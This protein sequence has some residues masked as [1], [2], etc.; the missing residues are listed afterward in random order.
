MKRSWIILTVAFLAG[1]VPT[2][3]DPSLV[4]NEL[5]ARNNAGLQDSAGD[6]DDWIEIYNLDS[7]SVDVGGMHLTDNLSNPAK[8]RIPTGIPEQTTIAPNGF[9]LIWADGEEDQGPL[10]AGFKLGDGGEAVGL[11]D[12][13]GVLLDSL[14]FGPQDPDKSYGRF[15]D[16]R[17][18][19]QS[20]NCP[21]PGQPNERDH[22]DVIISEIM[23]HPYA[24][25]LQAENRDEEYIELFNR[26]SEAVSL[27]GWTITEGVRFGFPDV[28]LESGGYLVVA[29]DVEAFAARYPEV[30]NVVGGWD[31]RLSNSGETVELHDTA[32]VVVDRV[33]YADNGDWSV[34][35]L[36]PAQYGH[37]GWTWRDDHDGGGKSLEL[38]N[39]TLSN[40]FGQNWIASDPNGGTPGIANSVATT[41]TTPLIAD[42]G[43]VP[44]VPGP[45]D[46]VT[47]TARVA[48]AANDALTVLLRYR[49]DTSRYTNQTGRAAYPIF[50]ADSYTSLAM[51]DDGAHGDGMA[52]DGLY[53]AE[54]PPHPDGTVIEFYVQATDGAGHARTWPAPSIIDG[55]VQ[56]VT[57]ALYQV[58]AAFNPYTYWQIG[59]QPL[60]YMVMTEAERGRLAY[61]GERR[62][63]ALSHAQMNGTFISVDGQD[64]LLRYN[65]GIRN[66]GNGSRMPPPN[67]YRVNFP[68]DRRWK[69]VDAININSKY[70]YIQL[71]GQAVFH[72]AGLPAL[73]AKRVQVRVNGQDLAPLDPERMYGSYVHLEVYDGDWADHHFPDD[74]GGNL[75]RC[76]SRSR[77]CDLRYQGEDPASYG[78]ADWYRKKTNT[79]ANDWSD[80]TG[81][82]YALDESPDGTYVRDVE[83]VVNVDQ[84]LRWFALMALVVN[85][86]TNLSN[87]YGD[88]Y[89]MY[90][91]AEDERFMLLP[92]DLDSVLISPDPNTSIWLA[93]R[94]DNL[95]V[96]KR[97]L[98]HPE[99]VPR[100]YAQLKDLAETVLAPEQFNPLVEQLLGDWVPQQTVEAIQ[101][102]AAARRAYVL[103]VIPQTFTATAEIRLA[104]DYPA[105][106]VPHVYDREICGTANAI[107]TQSV[108][109][110][111]Q[112][113]TWLPREGQ[114]M[115]GATTLD[116]F[117]GINRM[118][119]EAF[120][121]PEGTG[122]KLGEAYADVYYRTGFT[123]DYPQIA[124]DGALLS[125]LNESTTWTADEGPYRIT[126]DLTVPPGV[127]LTIG[128]GTTVFFDP[129]VTMTIQGRLVAEGSDYELLRFTRSPDLGGTW[130]GLQFVDTSQ[131]NRI[132]HA[133]IEYG[134][135]NNGMIGLENSRLH[136]EHVTF[137]HTD[138]RRI[139]TI[140]SSL[141]V[142]DSRFT[143]VVGPGE[144]PTTDNYSEHIWGSGV[145]ENGQFIIEGNMFGITPGHNDAIDFDGATRPAAIPQ[146]LNNVF[147]GGGDDALD[148]E[149][150]AHVEGNLF[151]NYVEDEFNNAAGESN[152]I[153]AGAGREYVVVR[154]VFYHIGHVAQIKERAFMIFENNTV[155]DANASA[156]Y[157]EIPG[158]TRSPGV[159]LWMDSCVFRDC[160][161][162]LENFFI[163]DPDW[164]TTEITVNRC[165]MPADWHDWG[166]GNVD[167]DPLFVGAD[168]F[169]LRPISPARQMG[170][171]GLDMGAYVPTGASVGG[172]P[173]ARTHR[174]DATLQVWGPGV[175][176]Y[177]YSLNDPDGPWSDERPI[178]VPI[179]LTDL[180]DGDAYTVYVLGKNSAGIWQ[181]QANASRTWTVDATYRRLQLN[182]IMAA[183]ETAYER[184]GA[185]PDALELYYDGP[186]AINLAGM[187][188]SD[189]PTEPDKFVFPSGV[190]MNPGDYLVLWGG[191]NTGAG[192]D[193]GFG[194]DAEGDGVFLYDRDGTV[195]DSVVFGHQLPD[196]P[197]GRIG[198]EGD[199]HLTLPTLGE[200][201]VAQPLGDPNAVKINEWLTG[202][203]V[204]FT[205]DFIELYNPGDWPV[206]VGAF[207]LTDDP[208]SRPTRHEIRPLS[209]IGAEG[210]V[211]FDANGVGE[212]G[213]ANLRLATDGEVV[214]LLDPERRMVNQI[215]YGPQTPDVSQG[216]A[217]D[218]ADLLEWFALPTPGTANPFVR[219]PLITRVTLVH[220]E[221]EK[222]VIIPLSEEHIDDTWKSDPLFDDSAWLSV[223]GAPGGI[224]YERSIGYEDIIGLDVGDQ[225]YEI[226]TSCY[227]RIPFN[228]EDAAP[229]ELSDLI[230]SLRYDDGYIV[231][232]NGV[233]VARYNFSDAPRWNSSAQ[234]SHESF[235]GVFDAVLDLTSYGDLL[236]E[237][238]NLL[239]IHGLNA[240]LTSGDFLISAALEATVVEFAGEEHPHLR[241]LQLLD[242]LR[243]TELM[244]HAPQ[245]DSGDYIELQNISDV[246]LD[247]TGL[248]FTDG[249]EFVFPSM[250]L[251][252]GEYA[253]VV[254]DRAQ[255]ESIYGAGVPLAGEYSGRLSN[256]GEHVVLKLPSPWEMA[257]M[258]FAYE[259]CWH[260]STDGDGRSLV[261]EELTA[262]PV[263]WNDPGN[264][265]A[266]LPSPGRP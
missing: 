80:L 63:Q 125:E 41:D 233:E 238:H 75:Y 219:Q 30:E 114:W 118:V 72:M 113:V 164:G 187:S 186:A 264:W 11:Y 235:L 56:Q 184:G 262:A 259:D 52:R 1:A 9:L 153:S 96:I 150:D 109:V 18:A 35:E 195:L 228:I 16:G 115:L 255:F 217:P 225:M 99:F 202:A 256:R 65:V 54:V 98:T 201:N 119:A 244:Y 128:P 25:A 97:F 215:I 51:F 58:D 239:A 53:G 64:I 174:R 78:Q 38:A 60:Y 91:G 94:I 111:G 230:L 194:L 200:M 168:D 222:R 140:D 42:V 15:P 198:S 87:G 258:R 50:D 67:N 254:E 137:D 169:H 229:D 177:K 199:W 103:S 108:L 24:D 213:L 121:G 123:N 129:N 247:L 110:N 68:H 204:L 48:G 220:E 151:M 171:C 162:L 112:T 240:S 117:P 55:E 3:G 163:D 176:H 105:K 156:F 246:A 40:E 37:R 49:V 4:I 236:H 211:A 19:W 231:Y 181:M 189:D 192:L 188:L 154:N 17:G 182:E 23:Y 212:P 46:P 104:G 126:A 208:T 102:F 131:D 209:F 216:R 45:V 179:T 27:G 14:T 234:G 158:R 206:D 185:F 141:V 57:N 5:L 21:T 214:G 139:R 146:I 205:H 34:R 142:R 107:E 266:A 77:Y 133:V 59:S 170:A 31:G 28:V 167:A 196:L 36:G 143:N 243:I 7:Q 265:H 73:D 39:L 149:T 138:L 226:N 13:A 82:T 100:Y 160:P 178:D 242:G 33:T 248:R 81:L 252:A 43:H 245:G 224:G 157:F 190:T 26:G 71:L 152:V 127:T 20:F 237:G 249:V 155:V 134:R 66:R 203:A 116:L 180:S 166:Q 106:T 263:M 2:A 32:D 8:W 193:L 6:H 22:A 197:L 159:G 173:A 227:V 120:A 89:C 29:A 86:E 210:F 241:E 144:P 90:R 175:T 10:H 148:L 62:N 85:R 61:L 136:V 183:N 70:T 135:T 191:D 130:G 88:D 76:V 84:W 221:A 172:E 223:S 232:L 253:L 95:P 74:S 218:G 69:G 251:E 44:V 260:P 161:V 250:A 122:R 257:I 93:D 124:G 101:S 261:V 207:Y 83:A 12:A 147:T 132:A 165:L 47:V 92:Y 145:P 79:A